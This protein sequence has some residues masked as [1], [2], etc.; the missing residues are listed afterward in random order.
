MT[1]RQ[2]RRTT[3]KSTDGSFTQKEHSVPEAQH[4]SPAADAEVELYSSPDGA[5]SLLVRFADDTV[6]ATQ[7]QIAELFGVDVRTVNEHV[8]NAL[9]EGE[10]DGEATSRNFR[11][12]R[13]EDAR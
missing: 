5:I 3:A 8:H 7:A 2:P 4:G 12:V 6:W 10:L 9:D 11:I 1:D 13:L